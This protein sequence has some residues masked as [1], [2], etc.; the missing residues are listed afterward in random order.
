M[1]ESG[2]DLAVP[3]DDA[4]SVGTGA[5]GAPV[6][7]KEARVVDEYGAEVPDGNSGE[8]VVRGEPMML[9]YWNQ[10][11]KTAEILRDGWLHTGDLVYKDDRGYFHWIGRLKDMVRRGG[12]NI[13]SA[14]VEGVILEHPAIKSAAVVPVPDPLRG[15]EVKV[16]VILQDGYTQ[17]SIPPHEIVDF[18]ARK[19]A[20]FKLPRYVA[21]VDQFPL[22][23]SERIAKH[24]LIRGVSD[25]RLN[26]YD[27]LE[28]I[29]R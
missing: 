4:A 14:E 28:Q 8:L 3:L 13:S 16:F 5:M 2:V 9:G 18:A 24:E 23:P 27:L 26:S 25:L 1:T 21:Y 11:E 22:T 12:E 19:L 15:E 17:E 20:K 7:T 29:W 10:P 6:H